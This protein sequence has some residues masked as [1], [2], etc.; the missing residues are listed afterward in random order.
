MVFEACRG[1]FLEG[2]VLGDGK[3]APRQPLLLPRAHGCMYLNSWF[4]L[5]TCIPCSYCSLVGFSPIL[6]KWPL[7]D[8]TE[9]A[10]GCLVLFEGRLSLRS[11]CGEAIAAMMEE[12]YTNQ[13]KYLR[14][15]K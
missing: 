3:T 6:A 10:V 8:M 5:M 7:T 12:R 11:R 9:G 14:D 1:D 15:R 13:K 2:E 4:S